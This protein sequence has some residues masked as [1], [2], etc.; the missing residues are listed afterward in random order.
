MQQQEHTLTGII[1]CYQ[2][3]FKLGQKKSQHFLQ[4]HIKELATGNVSYIYYTSHYITHQ[5]TEI[6]AMNDAVTWPNFS[7]A[8]QTNS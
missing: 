4:K 3:P 5:R 6:T 2:P 8:T 7:P 1:C